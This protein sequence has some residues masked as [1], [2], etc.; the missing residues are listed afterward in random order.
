MI[1]F[2]FIIYGCN[3]SRIINPKGYTTENIILVTLDGVRWEEVFTGA[4]PNI[5]NND[6]LVVDVEETNKN[7]WHDNDIQRRKKLMP[8]LW[9]TISQ[10]GQIYGNKL[11]GS[12]MELINSYFFSYPG[13]SELLT[14]FSDDSVN[15]N[16]K[17]Y[18]PNKNVL[19][20]MNEKD[21]L[22]MLLQLLL[23]GMFLIG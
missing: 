15:S 1:I 5:I 4:D 2:C 16:N 17:K 20:F 19:E 3:N 22:E 11:K 21:D 12:S 18:N 14:G 7:Y 9:S 8:F 6:T 10:S 23:H 13:Y